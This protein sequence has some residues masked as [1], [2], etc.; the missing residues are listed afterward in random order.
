M[1]TTVIKS[2]TNEAVAAD[3][4]YAARFTGIPTRDAVAT[5]HSLKVRIA[6]IEGDFDQIFERTLSTCNVLKVPIAAR[7]SK[8]KRKVAANFQICQMNRYLTDSSSALQPYILC[9][10]KFCRQTAS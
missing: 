3:R 1:L 7:S 6:T 2:F 8:R 10:R 5:P 9:Q 4:G